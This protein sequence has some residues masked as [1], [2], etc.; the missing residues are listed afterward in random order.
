[1]KN[2]ITEKENKNLK[3]KIEK[4]ENQIKEN[5]SAK[6][7]VLPTP[8]Q[9]KVIP[10]LLQGRDVLGTANTGTGKT[11]AR[12]GRPARIP[13]RRCFGKGN[14]GSVI[15]GGKPDTAARHRHARNV[16]VRMPVLRQRGVARAGSIDGRHG[17]GAPRRAQ[18]AR[19][20][21][22]GRSPR[23]LDPTHWG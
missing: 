1:M 13:H 2:E 15:H 11:A 9:D 17:S 14:T 21:G 7:Y 16:T 4:L 12:T 3:M 20:S 10:A 22:S 19:C 18:T 23:S 5:I 8:I 6:G